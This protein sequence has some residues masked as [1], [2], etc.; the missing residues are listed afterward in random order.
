MPGEVRSVKAYEAVA[1][2]LATAG[3][4]RV[5]GVLGEDTAPLFVAASQRGIHYHAARHENQ[6]VAMADGYSRVS[7]KL[8]VATVTGGPGFT[9]GLSAITTAARAR[10]RVLL[11]SGSGRPEE[12]EDDPETIRVIGHRGLPK[13]F[14]HSRVLDDLDM[15]WFKPRDAGSAV[16]ATLDAVAHAQAGMATLLLGRRLLLDPVP[17][18]GL[19]APRPPMPPAPDPQAIHDVADLLGQ[20]WAVRRPLVLAGRGALVS[21]A[22]LA[23]RRL[24]ELTGALLATT[25][26]AAGLFADDDFDIGICGTF[27]TPIALELIGQVD[28]VL[29]FGAGLNPFTTYD[30]TLFPKAQLVQV[31]S[32]TEELGRLMQPVLTVAADARLTAEALVGELE[33]RGHAATGFRTEQNKA[34]I[35]GYRSGD[36]LTERSTPTHI[37]PN[38]LVLELD[39]ILPWVRI[40]CTDA[41]QHMRFN[42]RHLTFRGGRNFVWGVEFG[43]VGL[44]L[45]LAIGAQVARP[46]TPVIAL[47][48]DGGLMMALGD[49]ETVRRFGL[50]MLIVVSNDDGFGAEVNVLSNLG[51]D[52]ALA[53]TPGPSFAEIACA[54]DIPAA[55]VRTREDLDVARQW[56]LAGRPGP[57]LLDCRVNQAVRAT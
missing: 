16:A 34:A 14:R 57:L 46:E 20:N 31:D 48:G 51:V 38:T 22:G 25:V 15:A 44:C 29:S 39:R 1:D 11:I 19:A 17:S 32:R 50:P 52:P 23:L 41:G 54:L 2:G 27:A 43:T 10:S 24:A 4:E 30:Y 28:C 36:G 12:D 6:A 13:R 42:M 56:F 5:F 35:A 3:V 9:N 55:V 37:D 33:R 18:T 53:K 40:I 26:P 21:D 8:G 49:L 7:G 47:I 45:G